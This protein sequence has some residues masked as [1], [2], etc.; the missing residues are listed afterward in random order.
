MIDAIGIRRMERSELELALDWAAEEGWNPGLNDARCFYAADPDGFF[1]AEMDDEPVGSISAVRHGPSFGF[2]GL[3]LVRP[4]V[5]GRGIGLQLWRRGLDHLG[6][7]NIGLDGVPAQQRNYARSGFRLAH[8]NVRFQANG[9]LRRTAPPR[10]VVDLVDVPFEAVAAF[11]HAVFGAER[12]PF[13]REWLLQ[14]GGAAL[15]I[16]REERLAAYGVLR[17]CRYGFKIG[18]LFADR[19]WMADALFD[20]LTARAQRETVFVD[21]PDD[22]AASTE[23]AERKGLEPVFHTARMYRGVPPSPEVTRVF[24]VTSLELG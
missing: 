16:L 14:P 23:M 19:P 18:P 7:R 15:G 5:R 9:M 12:E 10:A 4:P 13:L 20:A 8:G 2:V 1:I 21:V 11:D 6:P 22:N 24:G 17:P 3:Y